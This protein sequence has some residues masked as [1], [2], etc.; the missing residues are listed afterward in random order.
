M[1]LSLCQNLFYVGMCY[2]KSLYS[3]QK[4]VLLLVMDRI[5]PELGLSILEN[6]ENPKNSRKLYLVVNKTRPIL[7]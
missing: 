7:F 4:Y 1:Y 5:I 3:F 6:D 2:C